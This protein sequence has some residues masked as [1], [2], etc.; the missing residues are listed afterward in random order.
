MESNEVKVTVVQ[1]DT[2]ERIFDKLSDMEELI[3]R[4]SAGQL[5]PAT[6]DELAKPAQETVDDMIDTEEAARILGVST[7]SIQNYRASGGLP[8]FQIG[9]SVR[10]SRAEVKQFLM[11]HKR[12]N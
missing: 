3:K 7:R 9:G 6:I 12:R 2:I 1:P 5:Q 11:N 10:F 8:Y 4:L